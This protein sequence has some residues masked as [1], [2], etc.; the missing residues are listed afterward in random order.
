MK[1]NVL[2]YRMGYGG[3]EPKFSFSRDNY[4][5]RIKATGTEFAKSRCL[6]ER[7]REVG[8]L[9]DFCHDHRNALHGN[10]KSSFWGKLFFPVPVMCVCRKYLAGITF[11]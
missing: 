6:R 9:K 1:N 5:W 3:R 10:G 7:I 4:V 8:I 2:L 11:L